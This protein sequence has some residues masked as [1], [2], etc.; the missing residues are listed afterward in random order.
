M[1]LAA[2]V[3]SLLG[4]A[5]SQQAGTLH[6]E[7]HPPLLL[8]RCTVKKGC[9]LE[10][11]A[12]TLDAQWRWLH[13][14]EDDHYHSCFAGV[15]WDQLNCLDPTLCA[16]KC[17]LE[18]VSQ[19][20][21]E[22][23]YGVKT[24]PG[25]IELK[26]V[27][28]GSVGSRLYVLDEGDRGWFGLGSSG[29]TRGWFG[30]G[31]G[32]GENYKLWKLKNR[33]FSFD[34]D[35]SSLSCGLNGALYF[36]EMSADGGRGL[37]H[38]AAGAEFGTGYCDAQCPH[39]LKF[40]DGEA[41]VL[42]WHLGEVGAVG[43]YGS[44]CAELDIWEANRQSTAYTVHPC[45]IEGQLRCEGDTCGDTPDY[46]DCCNEDE[47]GECPCCMRYQGVCDKD[48][49]D[50][51]PFRMGDRMFY[52]LGSQFA[53]D[54]NKPITV[55]TQFLT[56][57]GT[58][59]GDLSEIRRLYLQD[60]KVINNSIATVIGGDANGK[61][62]DSVTSH[63]CNLQ[64]GIFDNPN[65]FQRK[66]GLKK[67]GEALDRGLVL[68]LSLWDDRLSRMRW[69]DSDVGGG[70][71]N[72][73]E[74]KPGVQ[75]GPCDVDSGVPED[76]KA[77][78]P[79]AY[80]RYGN[81][82]YGEIG[83]TYGP[84]AARIT[85]PPLPAALLILAASLSAGVVLAVCACVAVAVHSHGGTVREAQRSSCAP[86]ACSNGEVYLHCPAQECDPDAV[87]RP[88]A[89]AKDEAQPVCV[90][91]SETQMQKPLVECQ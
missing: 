85:N 38:N 75:R 47:K 41:N 73:S 70:D 15:G 51:N 62:Q 63:S 90:E 83:S 9:T 6:G 14:G 1:L 46:C 23:T 74:N 40:I 10:P 12:V 19:Q 54:T 45:T 87:Y 72:I 68:V 5:T 89:D 4:V 71:S 11:T 81:I 64:K 84:G 78:H 44:C 86:T 8:K 22:H 16:R 57:D 7:E 65:D 21:Y 26:Y 59:D 17:A 60:G 91:L 76:L 79:D 13:D 36:V 28:G 27:S 55:V 48:G 43:R 3:T 82:S 20:D 77:G 33:E 25:G 32:G 29:G 52:G 31:G 42:G 2:M 67:M 18:G 58:D 53:V 50:Y 24:V 34:V 30:L 49:C 35:V 61:G 37:G 56:S 69:L 39:D 66:G 88:L 80:V